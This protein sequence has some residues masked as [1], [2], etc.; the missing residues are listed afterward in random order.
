MGAEFTFTGLD[1]VLRNMQ[2]FA[3]EVNDAAD[4]AVL[5]AA[6]EGADAARANVPVVTGALQATI[7]HEHLKWGLAII[8]AGEGVDY[9]KPVESSRSAFFNRSVKP[10]Q[11]GLLERVRD[12]I[13]E[14]AFR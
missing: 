5:G 1:Q 7:R 3:D 11:L 8:V 10:I 13:Q 2:T 4:E 14:K 12:K 6:V 9:A